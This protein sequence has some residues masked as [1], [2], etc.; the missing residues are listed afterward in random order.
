MRTAGAPELLARSFS[1]LMPN[2]KTRKYYSGRKIEYALSVDEL[3][4][5]GHRRLPTFVAEFL[6]GGAEDERTLRWNR[7]IFESI[8][9]V[10]DT[11]VDTMS[12]TTQHCLFGENI[13]A[14]LVVGPTGH[15]GLIRHNGD[16]LLA[17]AATASGIPFVLSTMSNVKLEEIHSHVEIAPWMQ[18][19]LFG[20][21]ALTENIIRRADE[22]GYEVLVLTTDTNVFGWREWDRRHFRAPGKLKWGSTFELLKHPGWIFDVL[23]PHGFPRFENVIDFFPP[24]SRDT[25]SAMT[26][27][28]DLFLPNITWDTVCKIR[29]KWKHKLVIKGILNVEDARRAVE[30]GCDGIVLT[31]HGGRHLDSCISPIEVLPDVVDSVGKEMSIIIDSGF[32]RGGDI[33]KAL[34]LGADAV[35]LGRAVLYGLAAGGEAGAIKALDLIIAEINR[36]M[37]QIGC[38]SLADLRPNNITGN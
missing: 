16:V 30:V 22:S 5:M 4:L 10:P 14:P 7:E 2:R 15:N 8:R 28:P 31:N 27:L 12:R 9:L 38:A 17:R 6:E 32:R 19:Y 36:V 25:R 34:A 3:R 20:D 1:K 13:S 35:M 11:L 33:V 37:G 29:E 26:R 18:L 21:V 23:I 24:E